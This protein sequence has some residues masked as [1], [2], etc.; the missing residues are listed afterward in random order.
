MESCKTF[1]KTISNL[2]TSQT[3]LEQELNTKYKENDALHEVL[4]QTNKKLIQSRMEQRSLQSQL[5]QNQRAVQS[6]EGEKNVL[7][8][9][10][11]D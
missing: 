8:M 11:N 7:I 1:S 2:K 4:A 6:L 9:E 10:V 5:K 3:L